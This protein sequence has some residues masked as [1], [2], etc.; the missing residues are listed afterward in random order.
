MDLKITF[1]NMNKITIPDDQWS[2]WR[3]NGGFVCIYDCGLCIAA[4]NAKDVFS[5]TV[6]EA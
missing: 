4:Y 5:V 2:D 6:H 1:F 3:F